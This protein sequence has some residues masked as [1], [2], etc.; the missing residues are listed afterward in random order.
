MPTIISITEYRI[1]NNLKVFRYNLEDQMKIRKNSSNPE[2]EQKIKESRFI[3]HILD[4]IVLISSNDKNFENTNNEL[5]LT[6]KKIDELHI[7]MDKQESL[8]KQSSE[9]KENVSRKLEFLNNQI[10]VE[11]YRLLEELG[12]DV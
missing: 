8:L 9:I 11:K 7:K 3:Q 10:T 12:C 1:R 5:E 4:E 6:E 2:Q